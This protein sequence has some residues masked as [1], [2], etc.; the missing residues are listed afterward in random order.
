MTDSPQPEEQPLTKQERFV[1][2]IAE[3][4]TWETA[5]RELGVNPW[6][7]SKW[8]K[9]DDELAKQYARARESQG[10][11]YADRVID[12]AMKVERGEIE[13]N[14]GRVAMDAHKWAAGKRKPKVYGEKIDLTH[15]GDPDR[16]VVQRI[17]RVIV[18]PNA[19]D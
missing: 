16:P 7:L 2:I 14:A 4:G 15:G 11:V 10:D 3:G 13:P 1:Q 17:E 9:E 18:R 19:P 5:Q 6:H 8:L 12:I